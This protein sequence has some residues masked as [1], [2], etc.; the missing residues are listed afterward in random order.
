MAHNKTAAIMCLSLFL[1]AVVLLI[2]IVKMRVVT[3]ELAL[4]V[5][6]IL[7]LYAIAEAIHEHK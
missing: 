2:A 4:A 7:A 1:S 6:A 3:P 5:A